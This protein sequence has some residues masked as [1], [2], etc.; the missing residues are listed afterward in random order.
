MSKPLAVERQHLSVGA[1]LGK[2]GGGLSYWELRESSDF[3]FIRGHVKE[4]FGNG[5]I[6][7]LGNLG[8]GFIYWGL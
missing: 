2:H 4:G 3:V 5:L 7:P 1:V 6:S 8:G